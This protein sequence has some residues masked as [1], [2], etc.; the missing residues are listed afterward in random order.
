MSMTFVELPG[1]TVTVDQ[2]LY[3]PELT[4]P[5][6]RPHPFAYHLSIHNGSDESL[7]IVGRKWIV[8]D[9]HGGV[10]VVEGEGVVGHKPHLDPGQSFSYNSF[11]VVR[12]PST[13]S[14][15]FFG[16]TDHGQPVYVRV[17]EFEMTPP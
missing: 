10:L 12:E 1:L 15:T 3:Q 14:G 2:V 6:D 5:V 9:L 17:P 11:H 7:T 13:A 8:T 16:Q 4:A